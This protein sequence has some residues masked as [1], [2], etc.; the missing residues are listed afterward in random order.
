VW[1]NRTYGR[2]EADVLY[3]MVRSQRPKRIIEVR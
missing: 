3:A 1:H 2:V